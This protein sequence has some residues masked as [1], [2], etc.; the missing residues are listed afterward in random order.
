MYTELLASY[1]VVGRRFSSEHINLILM[2]AFVEA[3]TLSVVTETAA[4]SMG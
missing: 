3:W 1:N 4:G 2:G